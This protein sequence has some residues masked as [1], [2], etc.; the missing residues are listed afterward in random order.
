M[1]QI[2][3][4]CVAIPCRSDHARSLLVV[5]ISPRNSVEGS[6]S[7]PPLRAFDHLC[8]LRIEVG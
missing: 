8:G 1:I 7:S 6:S 3:G 4:A 5:S 2:A